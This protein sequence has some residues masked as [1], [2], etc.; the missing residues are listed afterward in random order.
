MGR[1]PVNVIDCLGQVY[2]SAIVS[3]SIVFYQRLLDTLSVAYPLEVIGCPDVSR[4]SY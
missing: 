3:H 2:D 4:W 1:L